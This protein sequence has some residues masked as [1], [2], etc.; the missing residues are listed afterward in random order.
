MQPTSVDVLWSAYSYTPPFYKGKALAPS[1]GS[2]V[3]VAL[4]QL[5]TRNGSPIEPKNIIYTWSRRGVILGKS[6]GLGKNQVVLRAEPA[7][8][9][10]SRPAFPSA[11]NGWC[12]EQ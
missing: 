7:L 5:V 12:L 10:R 6:S 4:P 8:S 2:V 9:G 11:G 3:L 1:R